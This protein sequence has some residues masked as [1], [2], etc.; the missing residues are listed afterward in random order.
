MTMMWRGLYALSAAVCAMIGCAHAERGGA[1]APHEPIRAVWVDCWGPGVNTPEEVDAML[2]WCRRAG[3]NTILFEVRKTADAYYNSSLEP[4]GTFAGTRTP[5]PEGFDPLGYVI[6]RCASMPGMRVEAWIVANRIW[7]DKADPPETNPPHI[8]LAHPEWLLMDRDGN[9]RGEG[10]KPPVYID[11][12][13]PEARAHL[14]AVA[15]DIAKRYPVAAIHL[16]YIRY[17][18]NEWGYGPRSLARFHRDTGRSDIPEPTDPQF[19]DWRAAQ[20]TQEVKEIRRAIDQARPGI[21]LTAA[22][23]SWG[24]APG[25]DYKKSDL[26]ARAMQDWPL[27]CKTGLL[28]I[29]YV[30]HYKRSFVPEQDRDFRAWFPFFRAHRDG[31]KSRIVVGQGAYLHDIPDSIAQLNEALAAG[32]DGICIFSYRV[33][34]KDTVDRDAFADALRNG[35]CR[36]GAHGHRPHIRRPVVKD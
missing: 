30:M 4:R 28:D 31:I 17:P 24:G 15:A 25:E 5:L 1:H 3:I 11:P 8:M 21:D 12:S 22:T 36:P 2:D 35:P 26:Y 29:N 13:D 27:W 16:D 14:A 23:V 34:N 7:A 19:T 32:L 20:V 33:T 9:I 10:E 18:G 6:L